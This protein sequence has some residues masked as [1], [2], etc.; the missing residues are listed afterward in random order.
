MS[1]LRPADG[2]WERLRCNN[3]K[4]DDPFPSL[5][6]TSDRYLRFDGEAENDDGLYILEAAVRALRSQT[7]C[8]ARKLVEQYTGLDQRDE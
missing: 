3:E 7:D 5:V 1:L 4:P 2:P 6:G 8:I